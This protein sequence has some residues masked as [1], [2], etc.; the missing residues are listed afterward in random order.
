LHLEVL[1]AVVLLLA[2]GF[3]ISLE[4]AR[5]VATRLGLGSPS[6]LRLEETSEGTTIALTVEPGQAGNNRVAVALADRQGRPLTNTQ[7]VF[8]TPNLPAENLQPP[9]GQPESN[10]NGEFIF[11]DVPLT[12]AGEWQLAVQVLRP[13]AFDAEASFD[14]A[15]A[16]AGGASKNVTIF[17]AATTV[18]TLLV[19]SLVLLAALLV[20]VRAWRARVA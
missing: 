7:G 10:G 19:I 20:G 5:Q 14:V 11:T 1:L 9:V 3:L 4:P 16:P 17:P 13:D 8:L 6:A 15:I 18:I 12:V 2:V